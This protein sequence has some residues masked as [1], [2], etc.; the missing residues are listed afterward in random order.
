MFARTFIFCFFLLNC[1]SALKVLQV[2]PGWIDSLRLFNN[3]LAAALSLHKHNVT[4]LEANFEN[5]AKNFSYANG[6]NVIKFFGLKNATVDESFATA[7]ND[8]V[9]KNPTISVLV[10]LHMAVTGLHVHA[11]GTLMNDQDLLDQ[12]QNEKFDFAF[13]HIYAICSIPLLTEMKVPTG[14]LCAGTYVMDALALLLGIPFT[15]SFIPNSV[16]PYTDSMGFKE[17]LLN[18]IIGTINV[19]TF[20]DSLHPFTAEANLLRSPPYEDREDAITIAS[21]IPLLLL[22]GDPS[23]DFPRPTTG[24]IHY[25]GNLDR[26][27]TKTLSSVHP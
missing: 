20:R 26:K 24:N 3:R 25:T 13:N 7:F 17:K 23:L 19:I 11:C 9:F 14:F 1:A 16:L 2:V 12:L 21:D 5:P 27:I 22:N 8:M 18:F 4:L 6:V 10:K 15:P